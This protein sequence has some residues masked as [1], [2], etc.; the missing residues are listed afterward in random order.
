MQQNYFLNL[1]KQLNGASPQVIERILAFSRSYN[2]NKVIEIRC[3][4]NS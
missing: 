2:S 1:S 3:H 4:S